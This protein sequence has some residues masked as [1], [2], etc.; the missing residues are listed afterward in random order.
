MNSPQC[1]L[2]VSA[3][4]RRPESADQ[5]PRPSVA[6]FKMKDS[7][8]FPLFLLPLPAKGL[9]PARQM[10]PRTFDTLGTLRVTPLALLIV[11]SELARP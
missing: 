9:G 4:C 2:S 10:S 11:S 1:S 7:Y 6:D 3:L 5:D 8:P